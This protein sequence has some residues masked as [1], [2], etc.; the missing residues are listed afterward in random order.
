MTLSQLIQPVRHDFEL[1]QQEYQR[2]TLNAVPLLDEVEAYLCQHPGKRL[3]PLLLLLAAKACNTMCNNHI[4]LATMVEMLHNATL[5]HDDVVDESPNRRG[6]HSV[7]QRWGNQVAVL[8]G[9]YYLAQVM[10]VLHEIGD[11]TVTNIVSS[12]VR[13]MCAGEL[14]QL[15]QAN[16]QLDEANY[17]DIIGCKT[18]SLIATC[19]QLGACHI[20][21]PAASPHREALRNFGY[22][23]GIVFQ[24]RDDMHDT[25]TRHDATLLNT[26]DP[27][28]L[29]DRHT[30]MATDAL[31]P[32]PDT[33]AK[34]ALLSLL[35]PSAPQPDNEGA[36]A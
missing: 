32:L 9:D 25:D 17:L 24:I 4:V 1:F 34:Q 5:M 20:D 16:H 35:L 36:K 14:K 33:P 10:T 30:H 7:R 31:S 27:Q 26:V 18:A 6:G 23:Y 19:C 8:C 28:P 2:R 29:I 3:R 13:T 12:T 11:N 15:A 22:H 21:S